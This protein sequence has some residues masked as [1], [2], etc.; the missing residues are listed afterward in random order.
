MTLLS[1][2]QV[3]CP[4]YARKRAFRFKM[5][6]KQLGKAG[7]KIPLIPVQNRMVG[8]MSKTMMITLSSAKAKMKTMHKAKTVWVL[9]KIKARH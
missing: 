8:L 9:G 3:T 5:A 1:F 7:M 2:L 6:M 4:S